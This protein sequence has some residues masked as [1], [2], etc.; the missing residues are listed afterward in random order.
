MMCL[1]VLCSCERLSTV[2]MSQQ[3]TPIQNPTLLMG[4][5]PVSMP[6]P[7]PTHYEQGKNSLWQMGSKGFFKDQRA[8]KVGDLITINVVINNKESTS[9]TP[10][11]S[12]SS[13]LNSSVGNFMG[14]QK[15]AAAMF[16]KA[17]GAAAGSS[18]TWLSAKSS[19][20]HAGS[21]KYDL[22]DKLKFD[23][24]ATVIQILPNGNMVVVGKTEIKLMND[25]REIELRGIIR[26]SDIQS[27]N[28]ITSDKIAELRIIY[29]GRGDIS[30]LAD[31][32]WGHQVVDA[33]MPF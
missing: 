15:E 4:Y 22:E 21:G 5:A 18:N 1:G 10:S 33:V 3:V 13:S 9:F 29:G 7:V 8:R 32:P 11:I 24:A 19:P 31:K 12:K 17:L 26:S 16:P 14:L 27:N 6:M 25:V 30:S 2:G 23:V 28:S 20:S